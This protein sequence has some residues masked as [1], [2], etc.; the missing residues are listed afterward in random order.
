MSAVFDRNAGGV[1]AEC[2]LENGKARLRWHIH[3]REQDALG[4]SLFRIRL[5]DG[6]NRLILECL[7]QAGEE[8]ALESVLLHPML[9]QSVEA[10]CLYRLEAEVISEKGEQTDYLTDFLPLFVLERIPGKGFLL[11]GESFTPRPLRYRMPGKQRTA[12]SQRILMEDMLLMR[13]L[14]VNAICAEGEGND[15]RAFLQLCKKTGFFIW[16]EQQLL[17]EECSVPW[18]RGDKDS[19]LKA[20]GV[21][22]SLYYRYEARW[23]KIPFVYILPESISC[24]ENGLYTVT[25]YSNCKKVALYSNGI[26]HAFLSGSEEFVFQEVP[27]SGPCLVLTAEAGECAQSL[28]L[29]RTFTKLS[30]NDDI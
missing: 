28:S 2:R 29:H 4:Q 15:D 21:K 24:R 13:R 12:E 25:V 3:Y 1:E 8:E 6:E 17:S 10:P 5:F 22:T 23:S 19:L 20:D 7:Q 16:T 18:L 26:L 9:W 30:R 14:G 27:A 11:N